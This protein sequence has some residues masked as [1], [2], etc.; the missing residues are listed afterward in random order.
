MFIKARQILDS[1]L[2]ADE[3]LDSYRFDMGNLECCVSWTWRKLM[4]MLIGSF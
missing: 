2:I 3:C 1:V 4:M